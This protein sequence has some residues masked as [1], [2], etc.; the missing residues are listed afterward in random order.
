MNIEFKASAAKSL[1]NVSSELTVLLKED[2]VRA[3][4]P[5]YIVNKL[6]VA[7]Q[8]LNIV[9]YYPI[10]FADEVENLEYGTQSDSPQSIFRMF[11]TKHGDAISENMA[12][13]SVDYLVGQD[14]IP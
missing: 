8:D 4:W 9:I 10:K 7:I 2:A 3:N 12:E 11:I 6:K 1:K 5:T 14:L 13:W